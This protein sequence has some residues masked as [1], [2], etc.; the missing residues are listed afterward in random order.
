MASPTEVPFCLKDGIIQLLKPQRVQFMRFVQLNQSRDRSEGRVLVMTQWR[1]TVFHNKQ[2][3]KVESSFSYLEIYA[4][5][6]ESHDQVTIETDRQIYSLSLMSVEDLEAVVSHVAASLKKIFPDSSPGKLLKKVPPDL[7]ERLWGLTSKVEEQLNGAQKPCGGFSD[8]YAALCDFNDFPCREEVQWDVDN[9]YHV[10]NCQEFNLLDFSHLESRDLAL[11]V[12]ALS[13]N[14]WFTKIYSK[15]FKLTLDVQEQVIYLISRSTA[16]QELSLEASGLKV[17]FAVK[18]ACAVHDQP[19]SALRA[20][21][22]SSNPIED[23]GVM[24]LSQ[25][26]ARL[27]PGLS[28]LYLS[29]VS[30]SPKGLGSIAQ[31]LHQNKSFSKSLTHLDLSGNTGCLATEDAV[32]LFSFLSA[33]NVVSHLDLSSTDCPLDTLFVSLSAGCC[34]TLTHLNLSK[35]IFSHRKVRE[36]TR[37]VRDFFTRSMELKYV[38]LSGTR[39]LPE[40]LRLLLQGLATN[41]YLSELELDISSCELKSSGAQVIQE[42]IFEAKAISSLDLSDNGFENDMVTLVLSIGRSHSIRHLALGRNF[43]MKSRALTDVLHRIVQLIQEEECPLESLSVCD[44]KL[45]TGTTIL[46]NSLGSNSSLSKIDISGNCIGD[47]G[48]KM[49]AKALIINTKLKTLVWDRNNVT[50]T[51]FMDVANAL[52]RNTTL[53]HMSIPMSDMTQSYRTNPEKTEEAMRKIQMCLRRNSQKLCITSDQMLNLQQGLKTSRSEQLVQNF[54]QRLQ[55]TMRPLACYNI[56]EVQTDILSAE[57]ALQ[58]ARTAIVFLPRIYEL[59][60]SPS[61]GVMVQHILDDTAKAITSELAEEIQEQAQAMLQSAQAACPRVVQ[62][63][64]VN[65]QLANRVANKTR[66]AAHFVQSIVKQAESSIAE[67]LSELKLSVSVS[68]VESI[69]EEVLQDLSVA[70]QKLEKHLKEYSQPLNS[71][72]NVPQLRVVEQ[73]FP[74]DEYVS[75]IW[76]NSFCTRSIRPAPSVKSLLETEGEQQA[77]ASAQ[78]QQEMEGD[79][80][81]GGGG[82]GV[83]S[84]AIGLS[85]N[86]GH[87]QLGREV[88]FGGCGAGL[89][90]ARSSR[91]PRRPEPSPPQPPMDLPSEGHTLRHY[92]RSRPRPN[93][94]HRQPPSKPQEQAAES[95][96]EANENIGRVDEGVEEFFTKKI[97]PDDPLKHQREDALNKAQSA[98]STCGTTSPPTTTLTTSTPSTAP[99]KNIKKK[100][101]DFFAFKKVRAG[102]GTKSEGAPEGKVK[103]TS[104]ADLIRP[105]REAARAEKEREKEKERDKEKERE[106]EKEKEKE[107]LEEENIHKAPSTTPTITDSSPTVP[108][109]D[110]KMAPSPLF[111]PLSAPSAAPA[112]TPTPPAS[113]PAKTEGVPTLPPAAPLT[114]IKTPSPVTATLPL[115]GEKSR[116]LEKSRTPDGERRPK[117]TRR[118]LREGKSQSLILLTGLEPGQDSAATQAKKHSSESS[119]TFEQRLHVML[120]RMG[121]AKTPPFDSKTSQSKEEELRKANSEGAILD[122]QPEPPPMKPRTMSTSSDTRRPVRASNTERPPLPERPLGPLPPKPSLKPTFI[123]PGETP[124]ASRTISPIPRQPSPSPDTP[125]TVMES[126]SSSQSQAK[127][128]PTPSPRKETPPAP[129]PRRVRSTDPQERAE[130]AQSVTEE[131][132]PKPWPRMKPS[133]QRRAVSVHEDALLQHAALLDP[134]ELKAALPRLQR[135]PIR[136]RVNLGEL[137]PCSED[138]PEGEEAKSAAREHLRGQAKETHSTTANDGQR[139]KSLGGTGE[140]ETILERGESFSEQHIAQGESSDQRT[141]PPSPETNMD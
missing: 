22:L 128:P 100:F 35:N 82:G 131:T 49:L 31:V 13:F 20:I 133:P 96:N 109:V 137:E 86:T 75:G 90:A 108:T 14:Q 39:L 64:S 97:I 18:M 114:P 87:T 141:E 2:P 65:E 6:I 23:K 99:T 105:L 7:Q 95:E 52:E 45:K 47:T 136:K 57:E 62:R 135:S 134:E 61:A 4:I 56:Q 3:V 129:S 140:E 15:D 29:K 34:T 118:S 79:R 93:R 119:S 46:I 40:A 103:K 19:S 73:V 78:S 9:I 53:Q 33:P 102:R 72:T 58:H 60:R 54:C 12:G 120:H 71:K 51:G 89:V 101:G 16:L 115:E 25:S 63:T 85:V 50:A 76:R 125:T 38:G 139:E 74:T 66:Q 138:L 10:Q 21:N 44:S 55:E 36:V 77:R 43:A 94:H 28:Q 5:S 106:K 117:A 59:G 81:S 11:A 70:Q 98:E 17:D 110:D 24:A 130:R 1:A 26:W 84:L 37:S 107:K 67:K 124:V 32:S 48:A 116:T 112:S 121:V 92:T 122:S 123:P 127:E 83:L 27:S 42:H 68:L 69:I 88:E 132:L 104:I 126:R 111:M 91:E 8:T 113:S 80:E 41:S 30:L